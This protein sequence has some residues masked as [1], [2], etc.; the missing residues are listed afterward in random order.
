MTV[1]DYSTLLPYNQRHHDIPMGAEEIS[2]EGD[3]AHPPN[4]RHHA[5]L[6]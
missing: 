1:C 2:A 4:L 6:D 3:A 5:K